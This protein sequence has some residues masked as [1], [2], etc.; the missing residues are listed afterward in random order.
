[1]RIKSLTK[2]KIEELKNQHENKLAIFNDIESKEPKDLWK[3]DLNKFL[4]VYKK[5]LK[6][7]NEILKEQIDNEINKNTKKKKVSKK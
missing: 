1:M 7:Y 2:S 6:K 3:E 5:N 4:E